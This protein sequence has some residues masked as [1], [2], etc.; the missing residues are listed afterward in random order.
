MKILIIQTAFLGDV[1]L[2]TALIE[3]LHQYYPEAKMDFLLREG[4]EAILLHHPLLHRVFIWKKAKQKY[5]NAYR[6]WR[7]I[8]KERYD[9]LVNA[10]RHLSTAFITAFSKAHYTT[11]F[12]TTI[13]SLFFSKSVPCIKKGIHETARNQSLIAA[14]TDNQPALP[15][16]HINKVIRNAVQPYISGLPY[17]TFSVGA[18]WTT[19][20]YPAEKWIAFLLKIKKK[21][22]AYFLGSEKEYA[23]AQY[24]IDKVRHHT[25]LSC[26]NL[27]G[28]LAV[29]PSAA[30]MQQAL[31]NYTLDS[32][33]THI[34]SA[35]NAPVT[36]LFLSTD[37]I[38]GFYPLS[39][40]SHNVI[41]KENLPCRPCTNHGKNACPKQH[42]RCAYIQPEQL[43]AT[44]Y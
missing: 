19:K 43:C 11:G 8:R 25:H 38:F 37:P 4:N 36:T 35:V 15:K 32:A 5:R 24:I 41:T 42:F 7:N 34:A 17:L 14:L 13:F 29:L 23:V 2:A 40:I 27:C 3:K 6:L 21:Y 12:R 31:M 30:L 16:L 26:V 44:L 9:I 1:L 20:I 33:P 28:K 22:R 18:N 39:D 10:Q